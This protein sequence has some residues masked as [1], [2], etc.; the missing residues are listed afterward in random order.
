MINKP[1]DLDK[2]ISGFPASVQ[3]ILQQV[4]ETIKKS[5]PGAV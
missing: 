4:R 2:Y 1:P 5:A 3:E